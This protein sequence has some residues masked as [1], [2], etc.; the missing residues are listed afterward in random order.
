MQAVN[1]S[2]FHVGT[3]NK[4]V[5]TDIRKFK[6]INRRPIDITKDQMRKLYM[7]LFPFIASEFVHR[8][9]LETW[10]ITVKS[11]LLAEFTS[12]VTSLV[13]DFNKHTHFGNLGSPTSNP[14]M[15]LVSTLNAW[16]T[17]PEAVPNKFSE[18]VIVAGNEIDTVIARSGAADGPL[19]KTQY[20]ISSL[21]INEFG[22]SILSP[23]NIDELHTPTK[24][25]T[26]AV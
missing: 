6:A 25:D 16:N 15:P 10:A 2:A 3:W 23:F 11:E 24:L 13:S 8:N 12:F 22:T 26:F 17:N 18:S 1:D 19:V 5:A 4:V 7:F 21:L 14:I 20:P 9:D